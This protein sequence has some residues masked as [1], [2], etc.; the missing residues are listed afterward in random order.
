MRKGLLRERALRWCGCGA[1]T[2]AQT[3]Q[4]NCGAS[5]VVSVAGK[6]VVT[7][8]AGVV[9]GVWVR[10]LSLWG[11]HFSVLLCEVLMMNVTIAPEGDKFAVAVNGAM[12]LLS[13]EEAVA[14]SEEIM[15]LAVVWADEALTWIASD[16][17][18]YYNDAASVKLYELT[19]IP[20][21]FTIDDLCFLNVHIAQYVLGEADA[22]AQYVKAY[23][24]ANRIMEE[25]VLN[26]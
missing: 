9:A 7:A 14:V 13:Q 12:A 22:V 2:A 3:S 26:L 1:F 8:E 5:A 21:E 20:G 25:D 10:V 19:L 23:E 18:E 15:A 6:G 24:E 11:T 16:D 17:E 4:T